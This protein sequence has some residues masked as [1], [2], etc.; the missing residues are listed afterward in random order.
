MIET[1]L[2]ICVL[3]LFVSTIIIAHVGGDYPQKQF[4]RSTILGI[5]WVA[6]AFGSITLALTSLITKAF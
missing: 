1:V 5:I 4:F 3:I 6:V 2:S